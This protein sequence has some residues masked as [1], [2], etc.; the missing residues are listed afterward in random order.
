MRIKKLT[1][2]HT[3]QV[4]WVILKPNSRQWTK[5]QFNTEEE[6]KAFLLRVTSDARELLSSLGVV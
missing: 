3:G 6:A 4:V 1:N 5:N 2:I